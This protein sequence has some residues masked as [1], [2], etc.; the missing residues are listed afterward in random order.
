V[1]FP[2]IPTVIG[3]FDNTIEGKYENNIIAGGGDKNK[4]Y[5][6]LGKSVPVT[7]G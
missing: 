5:G 4:V 6:G 3:D 7:K 2:I 1:R